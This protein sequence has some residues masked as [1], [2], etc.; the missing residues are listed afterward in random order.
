MQINIFYNFVK[1]V[2]ILNKENFMHE[3]IQ[4]TEN[5]DAVLKLFNDPGSYTASH[6]H[7]SLEHLVV[8]KLILENIHI[9]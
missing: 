7:N 2:E 1:G 3:I 4:P 5:L 9:I 8:C 6:W